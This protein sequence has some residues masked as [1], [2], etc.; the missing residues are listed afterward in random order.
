[1]PLAPLL[2]D[3]ALL[4]LALTLGADGTL[5]REERAAMRE[6][7]RAWAPGTDPSRFDHILREAALSYE[8]GL[9]EQRLGALLSR[10]HDALDEAGRAQV[11]ADLRRLAVADAAVHRAEVALIERVEA[12]W[13]A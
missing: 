3:L 11:L 9:G 1:M 6:Q 8:N 2:H 10:L 4:Y 7:L 13:A 5:D 12:A